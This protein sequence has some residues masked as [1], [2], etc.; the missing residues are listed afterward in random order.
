V[1]QH[2]YD[3]K[4]VE[5]EEE[6]CVSKEILIKELKKMFPNLETVKQQHNGFRCEC[7]KK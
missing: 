2:T 1:Q 7:G 6:G 3:E 4:D 5:S